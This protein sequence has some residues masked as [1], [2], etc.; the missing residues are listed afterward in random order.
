MS[1]RPDP[2]APPDGYGQ[3][4]PARGGAARNDGE[5]LAR[6]IGL[7]PGSCAQPPAE[8]WAV[9]CTVC[10]RAGRFALCTAHALLLHLVAEIGCSD[11]C[12][13]MRGGV[14]TVAGIKRLPEVVM[15][16]G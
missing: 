13:E 11:C 5:D 16:Y 2:L 15:R 6:C 3:A 8:V 14:F 10:E 9:G 12:R 7:M 1:E 4:R